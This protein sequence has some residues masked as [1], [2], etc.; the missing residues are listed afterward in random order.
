MAADADTI[1]KKDSAEDA[2]TMLDEVDMVHLGRIDIDY[3]KRFTAWNMAYHNACSHI[4]DIRGAYDTD[5]VFGYRE[6]TDSFI[7]TRLL[8][9]YEAHGARVRNIRGCT[10]PGFENC[11]NEHHNKGNQVGN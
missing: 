6:W 1:T 11:V 3:G 4:V 5:E 10:W 9:I 7:Y 8:K 2:E